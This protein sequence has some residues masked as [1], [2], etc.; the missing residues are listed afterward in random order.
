M[1][2]LNIRQPKH[3]RVG[4]HSRVEQVQ[5][6]C[7]L[8][9]SVQRHQRAPAGVRSTESKSKY[10]LLSEIARSSAK[11]ALSAGRQTFDEQRSG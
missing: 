2:K 5:A 4:A 10:T 3:W 7:Q 11:S 9:G 1:C 8:A 6:L